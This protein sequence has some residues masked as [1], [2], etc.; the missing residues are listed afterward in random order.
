[1][2]KAAT[3]LIIVACLITGACTHTL[4]VDPTRPGAMTSLQRRLNGKDLNVTRTD[5][6]K[7]RITDARITD[8]GIGDIPWAGVCSVEYRSHGRGALEGLGIGAGVGLGGAS[9]L[10]LAI[11]HGCQSTDAFGCAMGIAGGVYLGLML[12]P[13][14]GGIGALVGAVRGSWTRVVV[15][16]AGN[17]STCSASVF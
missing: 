15:D 13:V 6:T 4:H 5:G 14:T 3:Y 16:R 11:L 8:A 17:E 12:T 7:V 10:M 2:R 9:V 1:M